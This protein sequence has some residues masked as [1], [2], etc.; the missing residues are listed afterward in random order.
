MTNFA[1]ESCPRTCTSSR[2]CFKFIGAE[3]V[4]SLG[5]RRT[6]ATCRT[7]AN[8]LL[9]SRL[10]DVQFGSCITKVSIFRI[11]RSSEDVRVK[12][13]HSNCSNLATKKSS[14]R[15]QTS[16]MTNAHELAR[17]WIVQKI[18]D[19]DKAWKFP[20]KLYLSTEEAVMFYE[21]R[22]QSCSQRIELAI[23]FSPNARFQVFVKSR[24]YPSG[25]RY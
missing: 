15:R 20:P 14:R 5:F 6:D 17:A 11:N 23:I 19:N 13:D 3:G 1:H 12:T 4:L 18:W 24:K 16:P 25:K 9:N 7:N 10:I 8:A 21:Y 22:F 2:P